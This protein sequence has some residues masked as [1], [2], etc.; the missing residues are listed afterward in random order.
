MNRIYSVAVSTALIAWVLPLAQARSKPK[1]ASVEV[2]AMGIFEEIEASSAE[3]ADVADEL[4][5]RSKGP[6]NPEIYLDGL[7]TLKLDVNS[8]GR[9]LK[10]LDAERASLA[11][12]EVEALDRTT[13]L[14]QDVAANAEKAMETYNSDRNHLWATSYPVIAGNA[15]DEA[16]QVKAL[17]SGYLKLAKTHA[18]ENRLEHDLKVAP[19]N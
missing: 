2:Q 6:T 18:Q 13:S 9:E 12:W 15:S 3:I 11:P 14:M 16:D 19:Q 1:D 7:D 17:L 5:A 10:T 4:A 8:I